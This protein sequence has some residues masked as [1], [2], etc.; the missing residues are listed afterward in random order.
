MRLRSLCLPRMRT[1]MFS[2]SSLPAMSRRRFVL[3]RAMWGFVSPCRNAAARMC[4]ISVPEAVAHI[5]MPQ[6]CDENATASPNTL[7]AA[8]CCTICRRPPSGMTDWMPPFSTM[9]KKSISSP[10]R[11]TRSPRA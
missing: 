7:P 9:P 6:R 8:N 3:M 5:S 10:T 2:M 4:R 11:R 1:F